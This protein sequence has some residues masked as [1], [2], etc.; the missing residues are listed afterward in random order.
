MATYH[1][2]DNMVMSSVSLNDDIKSADLVSP[3]FANWYKNLGI[4]GSNA[5]TFF[6][7]TTEHW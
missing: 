4:S 1:Y 6:Y 2:Y 5:Q 7:V 3:Q